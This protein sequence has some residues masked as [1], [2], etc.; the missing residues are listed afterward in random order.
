M[1]Q[2]IR[3]FEVL[4]PKG[5][6][7]DAGWSYPMVMPTRQVDMIQIRIPPGPGGTMGFSIGSAGQPIIPYNPGEWIVT[8]DEVIEWPLEGQFDSGAWELFGY[9][10]DTYDHTVYVRFL[11]SLVNQTAANGPVGLP[12][13]ILNS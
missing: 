6:A 9:N 11:V 1:A 8:D 10:V 2:E 4:I 5:T 3:S 12:V 13:S 7:V